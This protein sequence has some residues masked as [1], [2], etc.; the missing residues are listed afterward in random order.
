MKQTVLEAL[1]NVVALIKL[2]LSQGQES[3]WKFT[4]GWIF[5]DGMPL[6]DCKEYKISLLPD[7]QSY[8]YL[9][10]LESGEKIRGYVTCTKSY[11]NEV[12][13]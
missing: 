8:F 4:D 11:F 2:D 5:H 1:F 3:R 13:Q 6:L 7:Q 9:I 10:T 12:G